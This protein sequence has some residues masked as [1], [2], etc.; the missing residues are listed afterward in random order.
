MLVEK[1]EES[2]WVLDEYTYSQPICESV[3]SGRSFI[4]ELLFY[5]SLQKAL[6]F[7]KPCFWLTPVVMLLGTMNNVVEVS[8]KPKSPATSLTS[9]EI[10]VCPK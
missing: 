10:D 4:V 7:G 1:K 3:K 5:D 2:V 9:A 8:E 6:F